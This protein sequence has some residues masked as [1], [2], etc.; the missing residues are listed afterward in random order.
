MFT[1]TLTE[2]TAFALG[3]TTTLNSGG[4]ATLNTGNGMNMAI[5]R[6]AMAKLILGT[7][8]GGGSITFVLQASATSGGSFSTITAATTSPTLTAT[9]TNGL[10][11]LEIRADQM[12]NGKP[13]LRALATETGGQNVVT[14]IELTGDESAY[15]PTNNQTPA[16]STTVPTTQVVTAP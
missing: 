13:W 6:R 4:T 12:P 11:T 5:I 7:V 10:Y 2:R 9:T 14:T 3:A 15:K 8:T 1:E 16:L